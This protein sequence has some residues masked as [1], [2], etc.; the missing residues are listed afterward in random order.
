MT[1]DLRRPTRRTW[2]IAIP[3]NIALGLVGYLPLLFLM[4]AVRGLLEAAG[5]LDPVEQP[6]RDGVT[7]LAV[8]V[9]VGWAVFAPVA[10]GL[11]LLVVRRSAVPAPRYVAVAAALILVPYLLACLSFGTVIW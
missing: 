3:L 8:L 4:L 10:I 9:A 5:L 2:P 1:T 6:F 11:N 7:P